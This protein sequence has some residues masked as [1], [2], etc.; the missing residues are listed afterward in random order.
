MVA[1]PGIHREGLGVEV[2]VRPPNGDGRLLRVTQAEVLHEVVVLDGQELTDNMSVIAGI[3]R[4]DETP[5]AW[6][7]ADWRGLAS[8]LQKALEASPEKQ[9][10]VRVEI[11]RGR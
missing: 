1:R 5:T 11:T 3:T 6:T 2:R 9:F 7:A 4:N 10:Q 8:A